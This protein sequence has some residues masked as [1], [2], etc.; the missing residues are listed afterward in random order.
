MVSFARNDTA[1]LNH[2]KANQGILIEFYIKA[3]VTNS[4]P[5]GEWDWPGK[6]LFKF[7]VVLLVALVGEMFKSVL[8]TLIFSREQFQ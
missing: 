6:V 1:L 2:N 7:R 8:F 4:L 3:S 5:S